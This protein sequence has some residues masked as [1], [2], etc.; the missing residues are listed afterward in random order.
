M[1]RLTVKL[2]M[3]LENLEEKE[4]RGNDKQKNRRSGSKGVEKSK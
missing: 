4:K 2:N 1:I 3:I